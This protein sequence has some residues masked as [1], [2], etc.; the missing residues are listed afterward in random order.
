ML[1]R[2]FGTSGAGGYTD[3]HH[4]FDYS[5]DSG[6]S[7]SLYSNSY[8]H[9]SFDYSANSENSSSL[10]SYSWFGSLFD[11]SQTDDRSEAAE[12]SYSSFWGSFGFGLG[13]RGGVGGT[14]DATCLASTIL[15]TAFSCMLCAGGAI[16]ALAGVLVGRS[17]LIWNL[18][19]CVFT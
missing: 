15:Q 10:Y 17:A 13:S 18:G 11:Q 2:F 12:T 7:S 5:A 16:N 3:T 4:S 19:R 9:H 6:N 8:T 14:G 1:R